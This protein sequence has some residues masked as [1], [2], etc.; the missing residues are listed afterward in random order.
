MGEE[1]VEENF[2][3]EK[4]WICLLLL[5]AFYS[6]VIYHVDTNC[7]LKGVLS[8]FKYTSN[9][10]KENLGNTPRR[11]IFFTIKLLLDTVLRYSQ[12]IL[13]ISPCIPIQKHFCNTLFW[14]QSL[15]KVILQKSST[16]ILITSFEWY[17][18]RYSSLLNDQIRNCNLKV[19]F[20]ICQHICSEYPNTVKCVPNWFFCL[21]F[22]FKRWPRP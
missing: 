8:I 6:E 2:W 10:S 1:K 15:A 16:N 11:A 17:Q 7:T 19:W 18:S 14:K 13:I 22:G 20:F 5:P 21:K 12:R 3:E 4:K 9:I